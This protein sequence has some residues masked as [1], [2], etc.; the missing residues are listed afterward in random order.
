MKRELEEKIIKKIKKGCQPVYYGEEGFIV[1]SIKA[2]LAAAE[3]AGAE[4]SYFYY[5]DVCFDLIN[6]N[7]RSDEIE[8]EDYDFMPAEIEWENTDSMAAKENEETES[9]T[10]DPCIHIGESGCVVNLPYLEPA[11]ETKASSTD[12]IFQEVEDIEAAYVAIADKCI[13]LTTPLYNLY[14]DRLLDPKDGAVYDRIQAIMSERQ[15]Y[16]KLLSR[17]ATYM[18]RRKHSEVKKE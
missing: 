14:C 13:A 16:E 8:A 2:Y 7:N 3:Y 10:K 15:R 11:G 6:V 18:E 17:L 4:S 9:E 12:D 1:I 5:G